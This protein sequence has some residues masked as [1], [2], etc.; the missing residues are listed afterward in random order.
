M[1]KHLVPHCL[2]LEVKPTLD[3]VWEELY[4]VESL[5]LRV[6][7]KEDLVGA[8]VPPM[9]IWEK[10]MKQRDHWLLIRVKVF[11]ALRQAGRS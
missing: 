6:S 1:R 8:L 2:P 11:I 4:S 5:V 9:D 3:S 7:S 10:T